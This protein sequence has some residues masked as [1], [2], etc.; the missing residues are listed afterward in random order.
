[1]A[2]KYFS[3]SRLLDESDDSE[4]KKTDNTERTI[5]VTV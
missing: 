1:M 5:R 3:C 4:D 2:R